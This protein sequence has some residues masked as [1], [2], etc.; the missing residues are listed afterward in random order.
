MVSWV[1]CA[2]R[3]QGSRP[4]QEDDYGVFELPK[5]LKAGDL[6]LVLADGM[7]GEQ[8][9]D[10]ASAITVR[11]F[12]DAYA[13][14]PHGSIPER[15]HYAL[16]YANQAL[17]S[18]VACDPG[19]L[20]GM[21]CTLLAVVLTQEE[22]YWISVGDSLLWLWQR[23]NLIRLNEDHSYR[24]VLAQQ[25]AAGEM[26]LQ[27][28][29][30]HPDRNALI[31]AMTGNPPLLIDLC[32]KPY[33]LQLD[34]RILLASDGLLTLDEVDIARVLGENTAKTPISQRLL[35]AVEALRHP[36]QDNVTVIVAQAAKPVWRKLIG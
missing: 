10:L 26:T 30:C 7:G 20:A 24:C 27:E 3:N 1:H 31:S 8:A 35:E 6:L 14:S 13:D 32:R 33:S 23:G 16:H 36:Y 18:E 2:G 11:N 4:Y 21:G 22:L 17:A 5:K 28:A 15:L 12:L 9:G 25:V 19:R 34:D 29:D